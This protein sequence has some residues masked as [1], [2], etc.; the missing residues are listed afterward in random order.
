[1]HNRDDQFLN[2]I[3]ATGKNQRCCIFIKRRYDTKIQFYDY[4]I[5]ILKYHAKV[6]SRDHIITIFYNLAKKFFFKSQNKTF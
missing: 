5:I 4:V 1:M 2:E 3:K 6:W